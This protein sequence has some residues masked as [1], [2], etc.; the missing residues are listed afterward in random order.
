MKH[1]RF[2]NGVE[3]ETDE[4]PHFM[5]LPPLPPKVVTREQIIDRL[6]NEELV[7]FMADQEAWTLRQREKF[8]SLH[9]FVQGTPA[10]TLLATKLAAKFG[11]ARALEI[12]A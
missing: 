1:L 8:R 2:E 4:E 3:V 7:E 11:N 9:S 10:W 6:N 5:P 12:L